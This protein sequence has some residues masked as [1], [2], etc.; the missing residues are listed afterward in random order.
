MS[1]IDYGCSVGYR[2]S[3]PCAQ[4]VL[5]DEAE[6]R[7]YIDEVSGEVFCAEHA[8]PLAWDAATVD[9]YSLALRLGAYYDFEVKIPAELRGVA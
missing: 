7:A 4:V 6:P 1:V 2:T 8:G 3:A 9:R 5:S